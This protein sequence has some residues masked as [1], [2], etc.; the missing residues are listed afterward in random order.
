MKIRAIAHIDNRIVSRERNS[1]R[2]ARALRSLPRFPQRRVFCV[3]S[4]SKD[5]KRRERAS[6]IRSRFL[7]NSKRTCR[8]TRRSIVT[9]WSL[10]TLHEWMLEHGFD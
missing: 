2:L 7:L 9:G 1:R 4:L 6:P 3:T 5:T 10:P 8:S